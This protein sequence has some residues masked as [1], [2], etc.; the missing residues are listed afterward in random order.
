MV[1]TIELQCHGL[2]L[3]ARFSET[4]TKLVSVYEKFLHHPYLKCMRIVHL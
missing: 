3:R 2:L 1:P 4:M